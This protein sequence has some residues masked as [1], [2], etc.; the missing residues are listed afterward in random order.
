MRAIVRRLRRNLADD[1]ST[2][3]F[4]FTKRRVGCR[5]V[6][7]QTQ[8]MEEAC[9]VH[10]A[11]DEGEPTPFLRCSPLDSPCMRASLVARLLTV[12]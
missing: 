2:L 6:E 12:Y 7:G 9:A 11:E 3:T 5:M 8:E 10:R 1:A 4:F